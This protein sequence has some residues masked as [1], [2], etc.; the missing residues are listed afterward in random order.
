MGPLKLFF[1]F[2]W[3]RLQ[4]FHSVGCSHFT[5]IQIFIT[6]R[7]SYPQH[8]LRWG[9]RADLGWLH[10]QQNHDNIL[11]TALILIQDH[12]HFMFPWGIH[13]LKLV[14][15]SGILNAG[16]KPA[17]LTYV[18]WKWQRRWEGGRI[19]T[20]ERMCCPLLFGWFGL[21]CSSA[22]VYR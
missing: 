9:D 16:Q 19:Y 11:I 5:G 18:W 17:R 12:L 15:V 10:L 13:V 3:E 21:G 7:H 20:M 1:F 4:S 14:S 22:P 6:S 8:H 2:S